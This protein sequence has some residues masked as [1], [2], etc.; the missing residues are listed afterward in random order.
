MKK[1][2]YVVTTSTVKVEDT[3]II[4]YGIACMNNE[5]QQKCIQDIS[6]DKGIV[7]NAVISFN[8]Y[9]L[10]PNHF[11]EAVEDVIVSASILD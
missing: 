7:Q 4:S 5:A 2:K 10:S 8:R 1:I 9:K 3:S 6:P 11:E